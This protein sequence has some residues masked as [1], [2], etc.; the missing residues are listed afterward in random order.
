MISRI[1]DQLEAIHGIR[2]AFRVT[3]FLIDDEKARALGGRCAAEEELLVVQEDGALDI[4]LYLSPA[5]LERMRRFEA[6]PGDALEAGELNGLCQVTEGVSHFLYLAHT[7]EQD[8]TL[9]L[10]E[11]EAQAEIDKFASCVLLRWSEP[12]FAAALFERLFQRLQ[13]RAGLSE[14][15]THRYREANR[16]AKAYCGKLL[17]IITGRRLDRLLSELRYSYRLGAEAK[18]SYLSST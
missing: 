5:L 16:L 1:Q 12:G 7:A 9:T 2:C 14:E 8:R 17:R 11:M 15:E 13:L 4:G 6:A 10:L 3:E 18:L